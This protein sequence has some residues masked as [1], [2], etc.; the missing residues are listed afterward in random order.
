MFTTTYVGYVNILTDY[1]NTYI[2]LC[3]KNIKVNCKIYPRLC[4]LEPYSTR[5]DVSKIV[6][7]ELSSL[8]SDRYI[9][10]DLQDKISVAKIKV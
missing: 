7:F 4:F 10:Q 6:S 5:C 1:L 8:R 3:I 9:C 2:V